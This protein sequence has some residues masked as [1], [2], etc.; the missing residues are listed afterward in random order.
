LDK[1]L[2]LDQDWLHTIAL[3]NVRGVDCH[4]QQIAVGI[5]HHLLFPP[6]DLFPT[7]KTALAARFGRLDT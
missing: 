5:G 3:L 7:V 2:R 1:A 6:I 4:G